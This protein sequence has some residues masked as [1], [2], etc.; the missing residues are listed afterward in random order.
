M[1]SQILQFGDE[2]TY[3]A[4]EVA[5]AL[6]KQLLESS[7]STQIHCPSCLVSVAARHEFWNFSLQIW[8]NK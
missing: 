6:Q 7:Y 2:N 3:T 4:A 8:K 1:N 5:L